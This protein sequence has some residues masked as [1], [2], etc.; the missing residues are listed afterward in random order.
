MSKSQLF[1]E[2]A[3]VR[4]TG[5]PTACTKRFAVVVVREVEVS[6]KEMTALCCAGLPVDIHLAITKDGQTQY[7]SGEASATGVEH[8]CEPRMA[9]LEARERERKRTVPFGLRD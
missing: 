4:W 5:S 6:Y 9:V 2:P 1:I 7:S 3:K 8:Y